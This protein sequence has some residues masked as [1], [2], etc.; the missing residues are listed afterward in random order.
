MASD[1]VRYLYSKSS[2]LYVVSVIN[3]SLFAWFVWDHFAHSVLL[4]WLAALLILAIARSRLRRAFLAPGHAP[5]DAVPWAHAFA[6][7]AGINGALWGA[8]SVLFFV[9]DLLSA[10]M[11]FLLLICGMSAGATA[12]SASFLPSYYAFVL[13]AMTPLA[14][15]L[16]VVGNRLHAV[17]AALVVVFGIA[18][19]TVAR[20]S[21]KATRDASRLRFRNALLVTDLTATQRRLETLNES[22]ESRVVDRTA[23]LQSALAMRDEFISIASHEL[24]TPLT[25]LKLQQQMLERT[26]RQASVRTRA[27]VS[28][29]FVICN[30][31]TARLTVLVRTLLDAS[32]LDTTDLHLD[33]RTV[34]FAVVVQRVADEMQDEL[35]R[36]AARSC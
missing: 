11:L 3:G 31:Q 35:R 26:L 7:A 14:V 16:V 30:R 5:R 28:N 25:S 36:R 8:G 9:P 34:D 27:L 1:Q 23:Q 21:A 17:L 13:P 2:F 6:L 22:L 24:K 10:Q 15:R 33:L 32:H 12:L 19:S 18:M 29:R 20:A 4:G